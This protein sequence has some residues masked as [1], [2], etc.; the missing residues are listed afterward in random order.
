MHNGPFNCFPC[1]HLFIV[2]QRRALARRRQRVAVHR[3]RADRRRPGSGSTRPTLG[4]AGPGWAGPA[5][6]WAA[7]I[8]PPSA[9]HPGGYR[10]R[11]S[12]GQGR[13]VRHFGGPPGASSAPGRSSDHR[14]A[15]GPTPPTRCHVPRSGGSTGGYPRWAFTGRSRHAPSTVVLAESW[16]AHRHSLGLAATRQGSAIRHSRRSE[17]RGSPACAHAFRPPACWWGAVPLPP[18]GG[19][20]SLRPPPGPAC[21]CETIRKAG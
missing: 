9:E 6:S 13:R 18:P 10:R 21:I 5:R 11:L 16:H 4:R 15:D 8:D 2:L 17:G 1:P 7:L 20:Y 12:A 3:H 14:A 19:R